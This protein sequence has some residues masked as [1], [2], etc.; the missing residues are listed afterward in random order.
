LYFFFKFMIFEYTLMFI[1]CLK[2][3]WVAADFSLVW[4]DHTYLLN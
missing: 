2:K 4:S 3:S 1:L